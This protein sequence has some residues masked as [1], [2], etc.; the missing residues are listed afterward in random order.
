MVIAL[1]AQ[2]KAFSLP[3]VEAQLLLK[4]NQTIPSDTQKYYEELMAKREAETLTTEE[5]QELLHLN[6]QIEQLQ[7]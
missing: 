1:Q 6:E 3:Q 7:A 2:R 5:H 4:I